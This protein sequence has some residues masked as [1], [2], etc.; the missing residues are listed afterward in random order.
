MNVGGE[1]KKRKR[2]FQVSALL[3]KPVSLT[4]WGSDTEELQAVGR[5]LSALLWVRKM[6]R[7]YTPWVQEVDELRSD[8]QFP[9]SSQSWIPLW[10]E[11][12][13]SKAS[14]TPCIGFYAL[15]P[16]TS[17]EVMSITLF[18]E[19]LN[20]FGTTETKTMHWKKK[21]KKNEEK[22]KQKNGK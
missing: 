1:K 12:A 17:S 7:K 4:A 11:A 5:F 13:E 2:S 15:Q 6:V 21:K 8:A 9:S 18:W 16:S 14:P 10:C 3:S 19:R 22:G 20:R